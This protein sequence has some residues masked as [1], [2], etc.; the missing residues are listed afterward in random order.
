MDNN[1]LKEISYSLFKYQPLNKYIIDSYNVFLHEGIPKIL[2]KNSF[3]EKVGDK[4]HKFSF[5]LENNDFPSQAQVAQFPDEFRKK[6]GNYVFPLK[7]KIVMDNIEKPCE[8]MIPIMLGSD[9]CYLKDYL[10]GRKGDRYELNEC[11]MDPLGYFIMRYEKA[12]VAQEKL[13]HNVPLTLV[14][15]QEMFCD[16]L[17]QND[18]GFISKISLFIKEKKDKKDKS[19][20]IYASLPRMNSKKYRVTLLDLLHMSHI[21]NGTETIFPDVD[22]E[23]LGFG[24]ETSPEFANALM[25]FMGYCNF[26]MGSIDIVTGRF[27]FNTIQE[28]KKTKET[29]LKHIVAAY[30]DTNPQLT[31]A[32][33]EEGEKPEDEELEVDDMEITEGVE[34][35]DEEDLEAAISSDE[36]VAKQL[37]DVYYFPHITDVLY[38]DMM[39]MYMGVKLLLCY[40]DKKELD[41]R[42]DFGLKKVE[43]PGILM[44]NLFAKTIQNI[45]KKIQ[46]K[47]QAIQREIDTMKRKG[48]K[49]DELKKKT[50]N[51]ESVINDKTS[52]IN[53]IITMLFQNSFV[54]DTW[55]DSRTGKKGV[56]QQ[57]SRHNLVSIYASIRR[58][59]AHSTRQNKIVKPRMIQPSQ[60]MLIAPEETPDNDRI[61]LMKHLAVSTYVTSDMNKQEIEEIQRFIN[62][63]T[64]D[65]EEISPE[66]TWILLDGKPLGFTSNPEQLRDLLI[67]FR[68]EKI[69]NFAHKFRFLSIVLMSENMGPNNSIKML[70]INTCGGRLIAPFFTVKDNKLMFMED[71]NL[72]GLLGSL[73]TS[74]DLVAFTR[75]RE[76]NKKQLKI[77]EK[78]PQ[79]YNLFEYMLQK[80][81]VEYLDALEIQFTNIALNTEY[82]QKNVPFTHMILNPEFMLGVTAS[83]MTFIGHNPTPRISL[84][85]NH[86]KQ[87]VGVA[88][89]TFPSRMEAHKEKQKHANYPQKKLLGTYMDEVIGTEKLGLWQNAVVAIYPFTG[90][91][92]EDAMIVKKE[93]LERGLF[94]ST[95]YQTYSIQ[96]PT[97]D[98]LEDMP[99]EVRN[100]FKDG[101]I[102]EKMETEKGASVYE[103]KIIDQLAM[104]KS[105]YLENRR[106]P[107]Y[108]PVEN[109]D[110]RS[111]SMEESLFMMLIDQYNSGSGQMKYNVVR[112]ELVK[113]CKDFKCE[114]LL[115]KKEF[116]KQETFMKRT[117]VK[118]GSVIGLS[119]KGEGSEKQFTSVKF[120]GEKGIV[121][122]IDSYPRNNVHRVRISDFHIA[123]QGDKIAGPFAQKGVIGAVVPEIDMPYCMKNGIVPDVIINP[124]AFPS[125][126]TIG[127]FLESFLGKLLSSPFSKMMSE[128]K[129]P[130]Y[131]PKRR[132]G[133]PV[134]A[135]FED[136]VKKNNDWK[137]LLKLRTQLERSNGEEERVVADRMGIKKK[138]I[139]LY[140]KISN[141]FIQEKKKDFSSLGSKLVRND[142]VFYELLFNVDNAENLFKSK[143]SDMEITQI[144]LRFAL[145]YGR[146]DEE[147][148]LVTQ[149]DGGL[150]I[151]SDKTFGQFYKAYFKKEPI[152]VND[153]GVNERN[154]MNDALQK[155]KQFGQPFKKFDQKELLELIN[156]LG[157]KDVN[158]KEVMIDG[159]TGDMLQEVVSVR[160][161]TSDTKDIRHERLK[162]IYYY[163]MDKKDYEQV[164]KLSYEE[165]ESLAKKDKI[166]NQDGS[167]NQESIKIF[168]MKLKEPRLK[169]WKENLQANIIQEVRPILV[170]VGVVP[171]LILKHYVH[172][173]IQYRDE[174]AIDVVT[175]QSIKGKKNN[176]GTKFG[177]M[178][179]E[180]GIAHGVS[181]FLQERLHTVVDRTNFFTCNQCK[182]FCTLGSKGESICPL[183]KSD[184]DLSRTVAP[185]SLKLIADYN[186]AMGIK[187]NIHTKILTG[188]NTTAGDE[189]EIYE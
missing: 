35:E 121:D 79:L 177:E 141:D 75:G 168:N 99:E 146:V 115:T 82:L 49:A 64:D 87:A 33:S 124:L 136:F 162:D 147:R 127:L 182:Q 116:D 30:N 22:I 128:V 149:L 113:F 62:K 37:L 60:Y 20:V 155:L 98:K 72:M 95:I 32:V 130:F 144:L 36:A 104:L 123:E 47:L 54:T 181:S 48:R 165:I 166:L 173:K 138:I 15:S 140:N 184:T 46:K 7:M 175:R 9:V 89:L 103:Q 14:K 73:N 163:I 101:I 43:T 174:G 44:Q 90:E 59:S 183:C 131:I 34:D 112:K 41:D 1:M 157:F 27:I 151:V 114:D 28:S 45:R 105:Y 80:G 134:F 76:L 69:A 74:G 11:E 180:V 137:L 39:L 106:N 189:D 179:K 164:E 118:K 51:I 120:E 135:I 31:T 186:T 111:L 66:N 158:E 188:K 178:E 42:D 6:K 143:L 93:A 171:F 56:A 8:G 132:T 55:G 4:V 67:K 84:Y 170:T 154:T 12:L 53:D 58:C 109:R 16:M 83:I 10:G 65:L 148:A 92:Q 108:T 61:G 185:Y 156:V 107:T 176:G 139:E 187:H 159:R 21:V 142:I 91:A 63:N 5:K 23:E 13:I 152:S 167:F 129:E 161:D 110:E 96:Q 153:L 24:K 150:G 97:K 100:R 86:I 102:K 2:E 57:V 133:V 126:L 17:S 19:D 40:T 94:S 38:K 68:R 88:S 26:F 122:R 169:E 71:K 52:N 117:T 18:S 70:K 81:Y 160:V 3:E 78:E 145:T 172:D 77:L 25:D 125:R 85:D 29:L 119:E 50:V